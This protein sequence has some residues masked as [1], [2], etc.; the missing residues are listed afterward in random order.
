MATENSTEPNKE[1]IMRAARALYEAERNALEQA[2]QLAGRE[3]Q[4]LTPSEIEELR[5]L[6]NETGGYARKAF[7]KYRPKPVAS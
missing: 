5:R 7:E 1:A 2:P 6:S 4:M 3:P